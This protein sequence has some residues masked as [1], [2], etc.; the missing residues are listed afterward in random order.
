MGDVECPV[1]ARLDDLPSELLLDIVSLICDTPSALRTLLLINKRLH[2]VF[3]FGILPQIPIR[4]GKDTIHSFWQFIQGS[5]GVAGRVRHLWI[6]GTSELCKVVANRCTNLVSLAC[7]KLV[8]YS[9]CDSDFVRHKSLTE[10][11]LF[12]NWECWNHLSES[13]SQGVKLCHQITHLRVLSPDFEP[14]FFPSLT[15]FSYLG[16]KI[17]SISLL[18]QLAPLQTVPKLER[19]VITTF[20]WTDEPPDERT[21]LLVTM[22]E[23]IRM[24]YFGL[25]EPDEYALWSGRVRREEC[26]WT[27]QIALRRFL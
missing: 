7:S 24:V 4:I 18:S 22:D 3:K 13:D 26:L 9:L 15:H 11:T 17:T 19:I 14:E 27:R 25:T 21:K 23:R 5:A 2:T 20:F 16:N 12:D 10:L 1:Y 8:L 6:S